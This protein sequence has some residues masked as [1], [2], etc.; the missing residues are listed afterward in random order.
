LAEVVFFIAA[1][2]SCFTANT[3]HYNAAHK[4]ACFPAAIVLILHANEI[5]INNPM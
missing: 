2:K 3:L 1:E 5:E 4:A